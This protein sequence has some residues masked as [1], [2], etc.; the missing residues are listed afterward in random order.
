MVV[1]G[2]RGGKRHYSTIIPDQVR[3]DAVVFGGD[4]DT[5]HP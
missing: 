5:R 2:R 3:G 1:K 4:S